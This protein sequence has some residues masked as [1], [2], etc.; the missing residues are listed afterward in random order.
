MKRKLRYSDESLRRFFY[1]KGF[2][3][4]ETRRERSVVILYMV[5]LL[6]FEFVVP[7][8]C[9]AYFKKIMIAIGNHFSTQHLR[10]VPERY[11]L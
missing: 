2:L 4:E 9:R 5:I 6:I 1:N 3:Q 10:L 8:T 11:N 7:Q